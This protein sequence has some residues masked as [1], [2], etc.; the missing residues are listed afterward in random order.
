MSSHDVRKGI[1]NAEFNK[2]NSGILIWEMFM[3][4]VVAFHFTDSLSWAGGVFFGLIF[5][6]QIKPLASLFMIFLSLCWG[7]LG[8]MLGVLFDSTVAVLAFSFL[9]FLIGVGAHFSAL[10]YFQDLG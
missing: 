9:G 4:S 5:V 10:E 6:L 1:V 3:L 7:G 8:F 2:K